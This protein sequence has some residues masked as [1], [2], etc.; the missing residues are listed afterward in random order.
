MLLLLL[1]DV[2]GLV[3]VDGS[4]ASPQV[5]LVVVVVVIVVVALGRG[6]GSALQQPPGLLPL[7]HDFIWTLVGGAVLL[8][9]PVLVVRILLLVEQPQTLGLPHIRLAFLLRKSLP[10]LAKTF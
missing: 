5:A 6:P 3:G 1:F 7:H 4:E 8:P 9:R 2:A 10:S